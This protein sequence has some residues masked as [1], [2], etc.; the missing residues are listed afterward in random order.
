MTRRPPRSTLFPYTTLFRSSIAPQRLSP[1]E[2]DQPRSSCGL[3]RARSSRTTSCT[4][5][6]LAGGVMLASLKNVPGRLEAGHACLKPLRDVD[7][8]G[9]GDDCVPLEHGHGLVPRDLHGD[10]LR[11]AGGDQLAD[12]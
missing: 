10:V 11:H 12:G 3:R 9:L 5:G 8:L 4:T 6:S 1:Q 7:L 2:L